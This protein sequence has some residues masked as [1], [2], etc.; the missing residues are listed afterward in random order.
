[1]ELIA[2]ASTLTLATSDTT[3]PWS[4]P[5]Y[6]V[7]VDGVFCFFS[8]PDSRHIK[9][10][11][12]TGSA[13]VSIFAQEAGWQSIRGIQMAGRIT[14]QRGIARSIVIIRCYLE[15]FPFT[16]SFFPDGRTPDPAAFLSRFNARLYAFEPKVVFYTDNRFGFATRE[17]I[18]WNLEKKRRR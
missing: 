2:N 16:R 6:Y 4:A 17:R 3:G 5:V 18:E 10:A 14:G 8:S 13:A 1:M 9:Q 12:A 11:L 15:R 7:L